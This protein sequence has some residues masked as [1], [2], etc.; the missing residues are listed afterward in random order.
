MPAFLED[1]LKREYPGNNHAVFGTMNKIG[2][3]RGNKETDKGRQMEAKHAAKLA[4]A[5]PAEYG[6]W[7]DPY[8]ESAPPLRPP[9]PLSPFDTQA[10]PSFADAPPARAMLSAPP[11]MSA[12]PTA[13]APPIAP[14]PPATE[15]DQAPPS[16]GAMPHSPSGYSVQPEQQSAAPTAGNAPTPFGAGP[17]AQAHLQTAKEYADLAGK[18]I[19]WWQTALQVALTRDP[20][21]LTQSGKLATK[22]RQM[23]ALG[24]AAEEERKQQQ[25][26]SGEELKREQI[27][28]SKEWRTASIAARQG[29]VQPLTPFRAAVIAA[30]GDPDNPASITPDILKKAQQ[31]A[32]KEPAGTLMERAAFIQSGMD[33]NNP[34]SWTTEGLTKAQTILHPPTYT[35]SNRYFKGDNGDV[36]SIPTI[37]TRGRGTP[38]AG[39]PA[40]PATSTDAAPPA[41]PPAGGINIPQIAPGQPGIVQKASR[42][43]N[44]GN[45]EFRN[46]PGAVMGEDGR[47]AKF[48]TPQAGFDAL[49]NQVKL[50]QTRPLTVAGFIQKYAPAGENDTAGYT[51]NAATALGV[52]P[53]TPL[54]QVDP[55]KVAQFVARQESSTT[56]GQNAPAQGPAT[57]TPGGPT[58]VIRGNQNNPS[59][60]LS[61]DEDAALKKE[62]ANSPSLDYDAWTY[63]IERK[64]NVRGRGRQGELEAAKIKHRADQIMT[65]LGLDSGELFS[66]GAALKGNI[67]AYTR[68]STQA[69]QIEAFEGTL[70]RNADVAKKL[71]ADFARGDLRLYNRVVSAFKTGKGDPEA[72]NLAAQ[73]HG[74]AL[75]W[76]KIMAG[77]TSA[78]GVPIS[79]S[80]AVEQFFGKG[81]SNGQLSSLI[82]NVII[83]DAKNRTAANEAEKAK[84][85]GAI[86]GLTGG[87]AGGNQAPAQTTPPQQA[88]ASD[89]VA[90]V[91]P[92]GR[93]GKIPRA[94]LDKALKSGYKLAQ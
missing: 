9:A 72:L 29:K 80:N 69:A 5:K 75:E 58:V 64:L 54:A 38:P 53:T 67:P 81:I 20:R 92:D 19:P 46:Q 51:A 22:E 31:L 12:P 43:N 66:R 78:A 83:P 49:V 87:V 13:E 91:A 50:D 41:L 55:V 14:M 42:N 77:S 30:G 60:S 85:L 48:E 62:A 34:Q 26:G 28:A 79:E 45:L 8:D 18:K 17:L 44:P 82:D 36:T 70:L 23:K 61:P 89:I 27:A 6:D 2:A 47:F 1:K 57:P 32:Q 94:N 35:E 10:P 37:T 74:L 16:M 3:M 11:A 73:L 56:V 40:Q 71:S 88:P 15:E 21:A 63:M 68:V 24:G 84:L 52:P 25:S 33:P 4:G 65:D 90:V 39:A 59:R 7:A 76:G 86:K 93:T